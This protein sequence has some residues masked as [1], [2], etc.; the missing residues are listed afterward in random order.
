LGKTVLWNFVYLDQQRVQRLYRQLPE[1]C[2]TAQKS[3]QSN[4]NH[5]LYDI[6][7]KGEQDCALHMTH[8]G[9]DR[10][11]VTYREVL[12]EKNEFYQLRRVL[13]ALCGGGAAAGRF[14]FFF[15][16]FSLAQDDAIP[17]HTVLLTAPAGE[18]CPGIRLLCAKSA[19][20]GADQGNGWQEFFA[21]DQQL[22]LRGV[23]AQLPSGGEN[24]CGFPLLCVVFP[25]GEKK[26]GNIQSFFAECT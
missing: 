4:T 7:P 12:L 22:P 2:R 16:S 3:S 18:N 10:T 17:P 20:C 6:Q 11:M 8:I 5:G 19:F 24:L 23:M 1:S 21:F 25:P 13:H 14:P 9:Q 15:G 26:S